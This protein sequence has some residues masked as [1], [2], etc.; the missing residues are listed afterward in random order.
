MDAVSAML[1]QHQANLRRILTS[2]AAAERAQPASA[3]ASAAQVVATRGP[4]AAAASDPTAVAVLKFIADHRNRGT[5][6]T[7]ASGWA[8]FQRYLEEKGKTEL[9]LTDMDV[10]HYLWTRVHVH[11]VVNSTLNND[12]AAIADRL[13]NSALSGV[14]KSQVVTDMALVLRT[15]AAPPKPKQ[16]MSAELMREL[17]RLHEARPVSGSAKAWLTERDTFLMLLMMMAYLREGEA[18]ALTNA[19][20]ELRE[21]RL[22]SGKRRMV[23]RIFIAK[24]K[25]DQAR[26]GA[27]VLL[28]ED[29]ANSQCCPVRRY[30]LYQAALTAASA[31]GGQPTDRIP[32]FPAVSG[33]GMKAGTPC[34]TVQNGVRA[35][36]RAAELVGGGIGRW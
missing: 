11:G 32:L 9:T 8:G 25:T 21:T 19:D 34:H 26:V 36:N 20:V 4:T 23:L 12:R 15:I 31:A 7:Y 18:V 1:A 14:M 17:V 22:P 28:G 29:K 2:V 6:R 30:K 33:A 3:A 5:A 10:A 16:H 13:K 27:C 35:A 24:S